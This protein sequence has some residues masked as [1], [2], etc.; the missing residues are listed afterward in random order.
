MESAG[1]EKMEEV[2]EIMKCGH[3]TIQQILSGIVFFLLLQSCS[4]KEREALAK[5]MGRLFAYCR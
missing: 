2:A 3:R 1:N 4:E 5:V